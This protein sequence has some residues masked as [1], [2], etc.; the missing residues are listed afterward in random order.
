MPKIDLATAPVVVGSRY[1]APYDTPCRHRVQQRLSEAAGLTQFGVHRL[2][3]P[4]G[5]WSSQ[6]HWH[7]HEDEFVYVIAGSAVLVSDQGETLLGPGDCAGFRAG[8]GN[9]HCLQNRS[10]SEFVAL[11]VGTRHPEDRAVYPDI[12]M[13][14]APGRYAG[15]A[16]YTRKDGS[17]L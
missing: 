13:A 5:S 12:D 11:V 6:R 3:L 4:P 1:P 14:L 2:T 8:D 7:S 17:S 15:G 10:A 9:G 16:R